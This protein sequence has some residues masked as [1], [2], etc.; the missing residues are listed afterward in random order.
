MDAMV[1]AGTAEPAGTKLGLF[2][3]EGCTGYPSKS[4]RF[5]LAVII[6]FY[7]TAERIILDGPIL[8]TDDPS[9]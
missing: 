5:L 3:W 8:R 7:K 2:I 6:C 4:I 1:R 9:S